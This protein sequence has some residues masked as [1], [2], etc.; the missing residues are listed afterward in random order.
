[1]GRANHGGSYAGCAPGNPLGP[2]ALWFHGGHLYGLHG[3]T[4]PLLLE[5]GTTAPS[6]RVSGGCVRNVDSGR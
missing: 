5:E 3:T 2:K 1:M 4:A 6:R